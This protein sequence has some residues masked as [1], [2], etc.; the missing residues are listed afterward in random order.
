MARNESSGFLTREKLLGVSNHP[1]FPTILVLV[2]IILFADLAFINYKL[3]IELQKPQPQKVSVQE[4]LDGEKTSSVSATAA[5]QQDS[6][7]QN[8]QNQIN[9][10]V[11]NAL[12]SQKTTTTTFSASS[13][14]Q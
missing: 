1:R 13:Q 12:S 11:S 14:A 4:S 9:T 5:A 6:C 3:L 7:G 10:A 2:L 8:C